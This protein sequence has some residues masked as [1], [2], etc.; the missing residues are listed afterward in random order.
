[1]R[2]APWEWW[3][4]V[5]I[6]S[7]APCA[8]DVVSWAGLRAESLSARV[9]KCVPSRAV[10]RIS[11]RVTGAIRNRPARRARFQRLTTRGWPA[12]I[13]ADVSTISTCPLQTGSLS[14]SPGTLL[15]VAQQIPV[16]RGG[17][18]VLEVRR[19]I[20]EHLLSPLLRHLLI[21]EVARAHEGQFT[22]LL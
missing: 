8:V 4:S 3:A 1:M 12:R 7:W 22:H 17:V 6:T 10:N 13:Q 9:S 5:R 2:W 14:E 16:P 15:Y 11:R 21:G 18:W 19:Q 20:L